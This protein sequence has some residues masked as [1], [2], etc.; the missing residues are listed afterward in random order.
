MKNAIKASLFCLGFSSFWS[1]KNNLQQG[2]FVTFS[3][4]KSKRT[5]GG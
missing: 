3:S 2:F 4:G 5:V 1:V